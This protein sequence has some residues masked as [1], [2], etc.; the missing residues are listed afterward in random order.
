M[1]KNFWNILF[2]VLLSALGYYWYYVYTNVRT[3]KMVYMD[4]VTEKSYIIAPKYTKLIVRNDID[5]AYIFYNK[6]RE[7]VVIVE[8]KDLNK[9]EF[10]NK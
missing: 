2:I 9:L 10:R 6:D 4:G 3:L 7:S 1:K 5:S 8:I